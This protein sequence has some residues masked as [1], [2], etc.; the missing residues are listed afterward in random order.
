M[1]GENKGRHGA[2]GQTGASR[3]GTPGK[4]C[5]EGSLAGVTILTITREC[6]W[7]MEK[8]RQGEKRDS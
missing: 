1:Q 5:S 8:G 4:A 3:A 6:S 7:G 2:T